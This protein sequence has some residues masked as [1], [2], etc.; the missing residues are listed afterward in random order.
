METNEVRFFGEK[1]KEWTP[2]VRLQTDGT[3]Q[4]IL[5]NNLLKEI[6]IDNLFDVGCCK[7][8]T[9]KDY[10]KK[11][12]LKNIYGFEPNTENFQQLK[13]NLR[14]FPKVALFNTAVSDCDIETKLYLA[15]NSS[16]HSLLSHT[17]AHSELPHE[18]VTSIRLDTWALQNNVQNL[19][20]V[21]I[22]TQG[23]DFR[24]ILGMGNLIKTVK[25]L[26]AE[27]WFCED[28]YKDSHLFHKVMSYLHEKGLILYNFSALTHAKNARLRWG[29]A[30]FLRR[31]I[32]S[33]IVKLKI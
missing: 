31:D 24:V 25:I 32:L 33:Q 28:G 5:K 18:K 21:K 14:D 8:D 7:G 6:Q 10:C 23:N 13:E 16:G 2:L 27:V 29:D 30:V 11:F 9:I 22:D 15:G 26:Q 1:I 19:D 12:N 20:C 4:F 3:F 17:M